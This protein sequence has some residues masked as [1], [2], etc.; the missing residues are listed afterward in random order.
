MLSE[1]LYASNLVGET[2]KRLV[3]KLIKCK[4][5]FKNKGLKVNLGKAKVIVSGGIAK[6]GTSKSKFDAC[7]FCSLRV[8][9]NSAL[10]VQCG[11]WISGRCT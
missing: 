4:E 7:G 6:D 3:N 1:L 10:Y 8:K 2:I 9:A 5:A 11:K